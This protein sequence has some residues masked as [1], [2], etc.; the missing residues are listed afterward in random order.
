[1]LEKTPREG[2]AI[3]PISDSQVN[4]LD[5]IR[6]EMETAFPWKIGIN[7]PNMIVILFCKGV[8]FEDGNLLNTASAIT[9]YAIDDF[10]V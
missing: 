3:I 5:P 1:M 4:H 8:G 10:H 2:Q 7:N 9:I 6:R